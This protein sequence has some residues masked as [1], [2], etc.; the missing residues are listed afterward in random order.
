MTETSAGNFQA[1]VFVGEELSQALRLEVSRALTKS[2]EGDIGAIGSVRYGRLAGFTNRKPRHRKSSG[3]APFVLL[4]RA[5]RVPC[6]AAARLLEAARRALDRASEEPFQRRQRGAS[7]GESARAVWNQI[8]PTLLAK[9]GGNCSR[10]DFQAALVLQARGFDAHA[11]EATMRTESPNLEERKGARWADA[12]VT[13][14][15]AKA[16]GSAPRSDGGSEG[17]APRR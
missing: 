2:F 7:C 15:V 12:Y 9:V 4:H 13:R 16:L 17:S 8:Y 5:E 10:A 1:W 3:L 14:T 11:I 6:P